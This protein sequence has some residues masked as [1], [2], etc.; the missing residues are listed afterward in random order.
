MEIE[1][2]DGVLVGN[3]FEVELKLKNIKKKKALRTVKHLQ[4]VVDSVKYTGD[5]RRNV[6]KKSFDDIR[7]DYGE[8]RFR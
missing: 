5:G 2:K 6:I 8:G 1:E 3:D 4:V 7:L